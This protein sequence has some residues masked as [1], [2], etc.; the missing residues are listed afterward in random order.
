[1]SEVDAIW[2]ELE[3]QGQTAKVGYLSRRVLPGT[4]LDLWV[5]ITTPAKERVLLLGGTKPVLAR[6]HTVEAQ[7]V[8]LL[9]VV[10]VNSEERQQAMLRL[11]LVD[12][13]YQ[14]LFS[15]LVQ[16]IVETLRP[17]AA[18][19]EAARLLVQRVKRWHEFLRRVPP[20]GLTPEEQRG[21]F[22]ELTFLSNNAFQAL[23]IPTAVAGWTG[24]GGTPHDF[25]FPACAV[26]VKTTSAA[27]PVSL[28]ISNIRQLESPSNAPLLLT[29][30]VLDETMTAGVTLPELIDRVRTTVAAAGAGPL[31]EDRLFKA[32]YH[33]LHRN[34]YTATKYSLRALLVHHVSETFPRLRERD[35]P[36]GVTEVRYRLVVPAIG[37]FV[38][39]SQKAVEF[40]RGVV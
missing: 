19:D 38:L 37:P 31:F 16:D 27:D 22:G 34:R 17:A 8:L 30:V 25:Q 15:L 14:D 18:P 29:A 6:L 9:D 3:R 2:E 20:D 10:M 36:S 26:E 11:L 32:G 28:P 1:M 33:D 4:P 5:G 21:L 23:D 7:G 24:P 39:S 13:A 35:I 12:H 40:L